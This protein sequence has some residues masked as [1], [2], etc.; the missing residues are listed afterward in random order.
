M[1]RGSFHRPKRAS[2]YEYFNKT[3]TDYDVVKNDLAWI[4][5]AMET[6]ESS[7][8][9]IFERLRRIEADLEALKAAQR[10]PISG[11]TIFGV[12]TS[13]VVGAIIILDRIYGA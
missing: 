5:K 1:A 7:Q 9:E 8:L 13:V 11:W 2:S 12:V 10:P 3:M 6:Q 4:R